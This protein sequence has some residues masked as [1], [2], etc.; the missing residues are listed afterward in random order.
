MCRFSIVCVAKPTQ[1]IFGSLHCSR[2]VQN[3]F[4]ICFDFVLTL[5]GGSGR[6]GQPT[7][8]Y[9]DVSFSSGKKGSPDGVAQGEIDQ[10]SPALG[11]SIPEMFQRSIVIFSV[12]VTEST[13]LEE[14]PER[15]FGA[16]FAVI[17]P[18]MPLQARLMALNCKRYGAPDTGRRHSRTGAPERQRVT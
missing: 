10:D 12:R 9:D 17:S 13:R 11:N 16:P 15:L 1:C 3:N 5:L 2:P 8:F 4:H 7:P 14:A 6:L 18:K